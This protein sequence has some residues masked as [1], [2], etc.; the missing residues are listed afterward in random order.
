M[1][2]ARCPRGP[3]K[4]SYLSSHNLWNKEVRWLNLVARPT[5]GLQTG[6]GDPTDKCAGW[7]WFHVH[8]SSLAARKCEVPACTGLLLSVA[9]PGVDPVIW[10]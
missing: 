2:T 8:T 1:T 6:D 3:N 4:R 7:L 10:F 9:C 5:G